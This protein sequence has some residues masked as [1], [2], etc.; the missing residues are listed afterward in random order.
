MW[1]VLWCQRVRPATGRLS[2]RVVAAPVACADPV[3]LRPEAT[4]W[5]VKPALDDEKES[6][7]VSGVA[8]QSTGAPL[9]SCLL[10]GDEKRYARSFRLDGT[11]VVPAE[12]VPLLPKEEGDVEW[13]ETDA[14]GIA[15]DGSFYLYIG[16]RG[17]VRD[18]TA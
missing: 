10:I 15:A 12:K 17:P 5:V 13:D 18:G 9:R 7:N 14:E 3:L 2:A 4:A 11:T 16:F 6:L 1:T 8:C